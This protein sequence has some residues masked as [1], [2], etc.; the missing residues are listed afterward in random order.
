[1]KKIKKIF[2]KVWLVICSLVFL[3]NFCLTVY[4]QNHQSRASIQF[5]TPENMQASVTLTLLD[6]NTHT[7]LPHAFFELSNEKQTFYLT[8]LESNQDGQIQLTN[9]PYGAYTFIETKLPQGYTST[10]RTKHFIINQDTQNISL[11]MYNQKL[12]EPKNKTIKKLP[13]V[14][15]HH[16]MFAVYFGALLLLIALILWWKNN[17]KRRDSNEK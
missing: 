7:P 14:G 16:L 12:S 6:Q 17:R 2:L 13:Q 10:I 15:W 4:A 8:N 3:S 11:V 1:M 9:L 5:K